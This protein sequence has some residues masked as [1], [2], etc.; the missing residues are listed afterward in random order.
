MARESEAQRV[1]RCR[2]LFERALAAGTTIAA[3]RDAD[4]R[5]HWRAVERRRDTRCGTEIEDEGRQLTWWQ[6]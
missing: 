5:E 3:A 1:R 2:Q 6:R 4:A